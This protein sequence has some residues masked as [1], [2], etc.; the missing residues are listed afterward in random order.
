MSKISIK[1]KVGKTEFTF[2]VDVE[3]DDARESLAAAALYANMPEECGVCGKDNVTLESNRTQEGY[4]YV[5]VRCLEEGCRA[6]STLGIYKEGKGGFWKKFEKYEPDA[7]TASPPK[8][9]K[10]ETKKTKKDEEDG[11]YPF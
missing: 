10:K 8:T 9:K 4:L 2:W 6:T 7:E 1:K 3:G 11:D 5:K